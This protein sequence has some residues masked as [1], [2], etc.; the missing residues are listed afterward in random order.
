MHSTPSF[1][2]RTWDETC[3]D[4]APSA[5][6]VG[7]EVAVEFAVSRSRSGSRS[8]LVEVAVEVVEVAVVGVELGVVWVAIARL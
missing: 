6:E 5:R 2:E 8:R 1:G 4:N 3:A 7:V